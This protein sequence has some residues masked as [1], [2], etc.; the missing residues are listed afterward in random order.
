MYEEACCISSACTI[1]A[2]DF[3]VANVQADEIAGS[4]ETEVSAERVHPDVVR[5]L[6]VANRDVPTHALSEALSRE[7]PE[8]SCGVDE[9]VCAV[10][11]MSSEC[12]DS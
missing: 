2:N 5:E 12:W 3:A 7:V 4:H 10:F 8:N 11:G 9:Y 6:R 1:A